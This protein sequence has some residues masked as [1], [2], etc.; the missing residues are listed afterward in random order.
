MAIKTITAPT[1]LSI[2]SLAE[3]RLHCKLD[4]TGGVHADDSQLQIALGAAHGYA[5]HYTQNALGAQTLELALDEFPAN[6]GSIELA[7]GP[8]ISITSVRDGA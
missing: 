6:G 8:V 4:T 2:V 5:E 3:M 1:L 7:R